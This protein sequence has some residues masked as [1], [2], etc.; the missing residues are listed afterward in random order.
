MKIDVISQGALG[1][2]MTVN[3]SVIQKAIDL[4][5][6]S[7]GGTVYFPSGS[8]VS[9]T[10]FL[11][12]NVT[13]ELSSGAVLKASPDIRDYAKDTHHNRYRN[14]QALDR[15]FLFARDQENIRI[16]GMGEING[17]AE[18]FPNEGDIYRPMMIRFLRCRNIRIDQVGLYQSAA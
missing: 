9:G 13:L 2:G 17:N 10:L 15:C 3:T 7:G 14:E 5:G 16:T 8:Y 6:R 11:K 1:D 12:S 4:C 18:A